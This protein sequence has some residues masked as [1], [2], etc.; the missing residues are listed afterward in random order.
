MQ[1]DTRQIS[2]EQAITQAEEFCC[3][4]CS[5]SGSDGACPPLPTEQD[6]AR[7]ARATARAAQPIDRPFV[8]ARTRETC[9]AL[10][11]HQKP[12]QAA[13]KV[14]G[15]AGK[16]QG[17]AGQAGQAGSGKDVGLKDQQK[18]PAAQQAAQLKP[19]QQ[20]QDAEEWV[21]VKGKKGGKGPVVPLAYISPP[22]SVASVVS[23]ASASS[24]SSAS[25]KALAGSSK[26][27]L[28]GSSKYDVLAQQQALKLLAGS[29]AKQQQQE[30]A[31][32]AKAAVPLMAP[33]V[34]SKAAK[35]N[36]ARRQKKK[37]GLGDDQQQQGQQQG[38]GQ[39]QQQKQQQGSTPAS[40]DPKP[41]ATPAATPGAAPATTDDGGWQTLPIKA[42]KPKPQPAV[43]SAASW[44]Q[45]LVQ[46]SSQT[47]QALIQ[48]VYQEFD[49]AADAP[50]NVSLG[51]EDAPATAG[52]DMGPWLGQ[53][54]RDVLLAILVQLKAK[55][56]GS[57]S[58]TCR[59]FRL[60][61]RDGEL[62][63]CLLARDF[64]ASVALAAS[65]AA[66]WRHAF[67]LE[68]GNIPGGWRQLMHCLAAE[69]LMK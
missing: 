64:P 37:Q 15:A 38:Q 58:A 47:H 31:A 29:P 42:A 35:K 22:A 10:K 1:Y 11:A 4:V 27:G 63:R 45:S 68:A 2:H 41:S 13:A 8:P 54:G 28:A 62:W 20:K 24:P 48:A 9:L 26:V 5:H 44:Q 3:P 46:L 57:L 16:V 49:D 34:L 61:C 39:Q 23:V 60:T 25:K 7:A 33:A 30:E 12:K 6:F 52:L 32:Q 59:A 53:L 18:V 50:A 40:P 66:D 56:M 43:A 21:V 17:P 55:D 19:V 69:A 51:Q 36:L 67:L 14:A 65:A